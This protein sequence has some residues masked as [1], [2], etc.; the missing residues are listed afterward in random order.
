M[1]KVRDDRQK[2]EEKPEGQT[3]EKKPGEIGLKI[4]GPE[5]E[6][7]K[8][9][10]LNG[11]ERALMHLEMFE[12]ELKALVGVKTKTA[13]AL[14]RKA[15]VLKMP[16]DGELRTWVPIRIPREMLKQVQA[17]LSGTS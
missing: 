14:R 8:R 9:K 15:G 12:A 13:G 1:A 7:G 11:I 10:E 3:E 2:P 5:I 17:E 16:F 6:G 4:D